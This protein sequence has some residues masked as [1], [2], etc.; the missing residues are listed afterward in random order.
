MLN[1]QILLKVVKSIPVSGFMKKQNSTVSYI[2]VFSIVALRVSPSIG[3]LYTDMMI[4]D[5]YV[6]LTFEDLIRGIVRCK[7]KLSRTLSTQS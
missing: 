7:L 6:L 5:V 3:I 4:A 2:N 1:R